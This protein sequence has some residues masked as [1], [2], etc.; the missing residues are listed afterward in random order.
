[1]NDDLTRYW[2][3]LAVEACVHLR[4]EAARCASVPP[5]DL[6]DEDPVLAAI[7]LAAAYRTAARQTWISDTREA[8]CRAL[9]HLQVEERILSQPPARMP[10]EVCD[11]EL[12][13]Y[14]HHLASLCPEAVSAARIEE[15]E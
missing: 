14:D 4:G 10:S 1:M 3:G 7:R 9:L 5:M 13:D 11:A 2:L 15:G 8:L 12:Y 6:L